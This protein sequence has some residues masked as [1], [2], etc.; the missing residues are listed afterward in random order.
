LNAGCSVAPRACVGLMV[1]A[2]ASTLVRQV[3]ARHRATT[4]APPP[5]ARRWGHAQSDQFARRRG[6]GRAPGSW[7]R[8]RLGADGHARGRWAFPRAHRKLRYQ[9]THRRRGER[10]GGAQRCHCWWVVATAWTNNPYVSEV[11]ADGASDHAVK[12]TGYERSGSTLQRDISCTDSG[13]G[14]AGIGAGRRRQF[15]PDGRSWL[16]T[17]RTI[18]SGR[19]AGSRWW[20][21]VSALCAEGAAA[22]SPSPGRPWRRLPKDHRPRRDVSRSIRASHRTG[23]PCATEPCG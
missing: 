10:A 11:I 21:V 15:T 3:A 22:S 6:R 16:L 8:A 9:A 7:S 23:T 1:V 5:N 12:I 2:V 20:K 18:A 13:I 17:D 14:S 4:S 19:S